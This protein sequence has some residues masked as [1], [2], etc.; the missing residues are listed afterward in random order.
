MGSESL[1]LGT[2]R[3]ASDATD[4]P[5]RI[6]EKSIDN[7]TALATG[8]TNNDNEFLGGHFRVVCYWSS[9]SNMN[10][11]QDGLVDFPVLSVYR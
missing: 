7:R 5:F 3:L 6:V 11:V 4:K 10:E 1:C 2:G 9:E 8:G